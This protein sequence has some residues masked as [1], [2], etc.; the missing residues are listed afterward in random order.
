[1]THGRYWSIGWTWL[2]L[3]GSVTSWAA[4]EP[5]N[6]LGKPVSSAAITSLQGEDMDPSRAGGHFLVLAFTDR[7]SRDRG[8]AWFKDNIP[9]FLGKKRL[10]LYNIIVPGGVFMAPRKA[11]LD[12]VRKDVAQIE[13]EIRDSLPPGEQ[14]TFAALDIRWHVD[15]DR[16]FTRLFGMPAHQVSLVLVDPRGVVVLSEADI[17]GK[18]IDRVLAQVDAEPDGQP[19][20]PSPSPR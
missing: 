4:E 16:R 7:E 1:M 15:F 11:I 6:I 13:T 2:L 10:A 20:P 18:V 12:Q 8:T 3:A 9:R 19:V 14:E 17:S 5:R